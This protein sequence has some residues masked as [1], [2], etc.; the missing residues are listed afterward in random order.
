MLRLRGLVVAGILSRE[1]MSLETGTL[2]AVLAE[3]GVLEE[4]RM[5]YGLAPEERADWNERI[6]TERTKGVS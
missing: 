1:E 2:L 5:L 3:G 4:D 6:C